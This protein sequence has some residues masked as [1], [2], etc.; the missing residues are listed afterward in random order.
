MESDAQVMEA[1]MI[2]LKSRKS[3]RQWAGE[4]LAAEITRTTAKQQSRKRK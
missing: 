2:A 4:I 1:R 3:L